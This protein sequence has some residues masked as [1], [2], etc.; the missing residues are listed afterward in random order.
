MKNSSARLAVCVTLLTLG[1]A[2]I[3]SGIGWLCIFGG[4]VVVSSRFF[5]HRPSSIRLNYIALFVSLVC[6]IWI[7]ID[8][9][10]HGHVFMRI[11]LH[12][13]FI[14][15]WLALWLLTVIGE[16]L[17]WQHPLHGLMI[18]R[19]KSMSPD[20]REKHLAR[21]D[22]KTRDSLRKEVETNAA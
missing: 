16:C 7:F 10:R 8:V 9:F 5:S 19:L 3:L 20:E 17:Q 14:A 15:F 13:G 11:P 2:F 18:R 21:L 22:Q 6:G 4:T 12:W 1:A